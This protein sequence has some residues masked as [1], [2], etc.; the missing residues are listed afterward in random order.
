MDHPYWTFSMS[1]DEC[2][3][4]WRLKERLGYKWNSL[5]IELPRWLGQGRI[6]HKYYHS[7]QNTMLLKRQDQ[8]ISLSQSEPGAISDMKS[9][10]WK[11]SKIKKP[12]KESMIPVC[13]VYCNTH[14]S[15]SKLQ[16]LEYPRSSTISSVF[17][18]PEHNSL[19]SKRKTG[20]GV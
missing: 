16:I 8:E 17:C 18:H 3:I 2:S 13:L 9:G 15:G 4:E 12:L 14:Y 11:S 19:L 20:E 6:M 5:L 7:T 1:L 10:F